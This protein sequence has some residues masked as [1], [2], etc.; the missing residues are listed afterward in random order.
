M[1]S[2]LN[3]LAEPWASVSSDD[4]WMP[5]GFCRTQEA[6]LDKAIRLLPRQG[7]RDKL[8][9]WWLVVSSRNTR[10][11]NWDIASTCTIDG[12]KGLILVEAKAHDTELYNETGGKSLDVSATAN[13]RRNH[14]KIGKA[15]DEANVGLADQTG[16]RWSLSRDNRYQ[17]SN[18][19]AWSWKIAELGYPVVLIYLGFLEAE[20][21]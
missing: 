13:S 16:R 21:M 18:R 2:R 19:F 15:I 3:V 11:P 20:E 7:E 14:A 1:A 12:R 5:E 4:C 17:M 10:T 9:S 8:R 6:E